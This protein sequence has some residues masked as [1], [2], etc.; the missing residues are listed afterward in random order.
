MELSKKNQ[1]A[2]EHDEN[3]WFEMEKSSEY[4]FFVKIWRRGEDIPEYPAKKY[5]ISRER[6][7][8]KDE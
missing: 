6:D 8:E 3:F 1:A 7:G 5:E 4:G 2:E